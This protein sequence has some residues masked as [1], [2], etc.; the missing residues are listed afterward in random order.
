M[1]LIK[2]LCSQQ[3][4][5]KQLL[6]SIKL[7]AKLNM[8]I[9]NSLRE[10]FITLSHGTFRSEASDNTSQD[11]VVGIRERRHGVKSVSDIPHFMKKRINIQIQAIN[12]R[13]NVAYS[14]RLTN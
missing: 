2:S 6:K 8:E 12:A 10:I 11:S 1:E 3:T 7:A 14:I 9:R 4:T 5:V 13:K